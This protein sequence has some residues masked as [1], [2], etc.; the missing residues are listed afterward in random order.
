[1]HQLFGGLDQEALLDLTPGRRRG[2]PRQ[3][4]VGPQPLSGNGARVGV[5]LLGQG[6]YERRFELPPRPRTGQHIGEEL[7]Q[8]AYRAVHHDPPP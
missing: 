6:L 2:Q 4:E 7:P 3:G 5:D 1:M 8:V